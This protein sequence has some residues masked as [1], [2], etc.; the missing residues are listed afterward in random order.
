M[1]EIHLFLLTV[2]IRIVE[3]NS[4]CWRDFADRVVKRIFQTGDSLVVFGGRFYKNNTFNKCLTLALCRMKLIFD[5][6]V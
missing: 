2:T 4:N 6:L 1:H 3:L 5:M